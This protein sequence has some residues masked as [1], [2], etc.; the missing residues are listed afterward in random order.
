[1]G[2]ESVS[3]DAILLRA[4]DYG[5]ADKIVTLFTTALG[6]VSAIA[7]SAKSSKRRF[8]GALE[9][10]CV[11]RVELETELMSLK[12]AQV[13]GLFH[14]VLG[15]LSRM[16][17]AGAAL[18]LVRDA[19][20][21]RV[22]EQA[23]FVS[24]LQYLT[25]L[26]HQ[27]DLERAGLLAFAMRVLALSGMAPRL[28]TCGRSGEPVPT[29]KA[30]YFDAVLGAVVARRLGGGPFLMPAETR[31]RLAAAQDETWLSV[32]RSDWELPALAGAR[33]ALA[34]FIA[35]HLS[36]ELASRL[37]PGS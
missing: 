18:S 5:D 17:A 8:G 36:Q 16:E 33:C 26:D 11:L 23:L 9:P 37:F 27:D 15:N 35:A 2:K 13:V 34:A 22:P 12:H 10:Y 21:A 24:V 4:V 7:R 1:V 14:G 19:V 20:A 29:E 6:K 31:A 30:A 3:T 28:A 25:L 32:A